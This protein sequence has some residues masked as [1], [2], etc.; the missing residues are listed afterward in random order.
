MI[1]VNDEDGQA[2]RQVLIHVV[3]LRVLIRLEL[4]VLFSKDCVVEKLLA[5]PEGL[6]RRL[7][8]VEQVS[9]HED[10]VHV[11]SARSNLERL[12]EGVERITMPYL[13]VLLV[14][15][16]VVCGNHNV[17]HVVVVDFISRLCHVGIRIYLRW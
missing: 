3:R 11:R 1:A 10:E 7:V 6:S 16:M 14:A 12:L 8:L 13:I 4:D 9:S 2:D 17:E 5:L 15:Q